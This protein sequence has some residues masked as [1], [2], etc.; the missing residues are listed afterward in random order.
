MPSER[1]KIWRSLALGSAAR[2]LLQ[3]TPADQASSCSASLKRLTLVAVGCGA[4][5]VEMAVHEREGW[6][7]LQAILAVAWPVVP[8]LIGASLVRR[9]SPSDTGARFRIPIRATTYL[10]ALCFLPLVIEPVRAT[11]LGNP[12]PLE[13]VLICCLRN[14]GVGFAGMAAWPFCARLAA[15]V[16]LFMVLTAST[17]VAGSLVLVLLV[18]YAAVAACWLMVVYWD[19]LHLGGAVDRQARLPVAA[20]VVLLALAAAVV[21]GATLGPGQRLLGPVFELMPSSGGTG[22]YDPSARGGVNDGDDEVRGTENARSIGFT[23]SDVTLDS[24]TPSLYDLLSDLFGEPVRPKTMERTIALQYKR[25]QLRGGKNAENMRASREFSLLRQNPRQPGEL[26]SRAADALLYVEGRTPLH[27]RL[28]AY[29]RFDGV[30]WHE[31]ARPDR[32][33]VLE[34]DRDPRWLR[35]GRIFAPIHAASQTH[36]IKIALLATAAL[37][38]PAHLERFHMGRVNRPDFFH[39]GQ[40]DILKMDRERIPS[41]TTIECES[42]TIDPERLARVEMFARRSGAVADYLTCPDSLDQAVLEM[43]R[44]WTAGAPSGWGRVEAITQRLRS[45]CVLDRTATAAPD[46][47]DVVGD[48]VLKRRRGPDYLF[49]SAAAL[50]I[51]SLG[52]PTRVVSGLYARPSRYNRK[53]DNTPVLAEDAHF[54][55]EVRLP[56]GTWVTVEPTPGYDIAGPALSWRAQLW[57]AGRAAAIWMRR[58][59]ALLAAVAVLLAFLYR[60]RR[61]LAD[62]LATVRWRLASRRCWRGRVFGTIRLMD[63]RA[64]W[65]GK[66]RPPGQTVSRWY[67][68]TAAHAVPELRP[69]L[70][71]LIAFADRAAHAPRHRQQLAGLSEQDVHAVCQR[72]VRSLTLSRFRSIRPSFTQRSAC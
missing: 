47:R 42:R 68:R 45:W 70:D 24:R 11:V 32:P 22:S 49:A 63:R 31:A 14:L 72:V 10:I 21:G 56:D 27:L 59:V 48:F 13:V 33:C 5:L 35:I 44:Q 4:A 54:W 1:W 17:M 38:V 55:A 20:P 3:T 2:A 50:M 71:R 65:A 9:S 34:K 58:H 57:A 43:A 52:Y 40:D 18:A 12:R 8:M 25:Q 53:T 62:C 7:P 39:W 41:G 16:S 6:N 15:F 69:D 36:R 61:E 67:G 60:F 29:D 23:D 66:P 30:A 64:D 28:L 46:C 19:G 37:P 26:A 51:R